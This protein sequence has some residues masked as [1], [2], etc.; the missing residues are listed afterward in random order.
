MIVL[1]FKLSKCLFLFLMSQK[2]VLVNNYLVLYQIHLF[3]SKLSYFVVYLDLEG[4]FKYI[5][6]IQTMYWDLL[7]KFELKSL[8][9]PLITYQFLFLLC[10]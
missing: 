7:A 6:M 5:M 1:I 10:E 8:T 3:E 4:Y 9:W 2:C